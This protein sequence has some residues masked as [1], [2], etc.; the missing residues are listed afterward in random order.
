MAGCFA[1]LRKQHTTA[2]Q[3]HCK[4]A[5][6]RVAN[7]SSPPGHVFPAL[8]A[9][10]GLTL[11][12]KRTRRANHTVAAQPHDKPLRAQGIFAFHTSGQKGNDPCAIARGSPG[13]PGRAFGLAHG[14]GRPFFVLARLQRFG[15]G[16]DDDGDM[17]LAWPTQPLPDSAFFVFSC[18]VGVSSLAGF[19]C[20][21]CRAKKLFIEI[22]ST[23]PLA[24][25]THAGVI[26]SQH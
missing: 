24:R 7:L 3:K 10:S 18:R 9:V 14:P 2:R 22:V 13:E 23:L 11:Q 16:G 1:P 21:F 19:F 8:H 26:T 17:L 20:C 15:R 5:T 25:I 4:Q 12:P 6:K